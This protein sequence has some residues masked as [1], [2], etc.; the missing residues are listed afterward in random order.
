M[1]GFG[2]EENLLRMALKANDAI[3]FSYP[4]PAVNDLEIWVSLSIIQK[5]ISFFSFTLTSK[6]KVQSSDNKWL[7][8]LLITGIKLFKITLGIPFFPKAVK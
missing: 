8:S 3:V 4:E 6:S 1:F 2:K 7:N 5:S